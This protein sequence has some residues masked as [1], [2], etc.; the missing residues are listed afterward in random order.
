MQLGGCALSRP[1]KICRGRAA[2]GFHCRRLWAVVRDAGPPRECTAQIESPG[3]AGALVDNFI[4]THLAKSLRVGR[5]CGTLLPHIVTTSYL[6][7]DAIAQHLARESNYHYPGTL[8]LSPGRIIGLRMVPMER[9][10]RFAW[11]EMP[12]QMLD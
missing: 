7:H 11:E 9:D 2:A 10:L 1:R 6:T 8:L 4:E 12:Q 3:Q 5:E